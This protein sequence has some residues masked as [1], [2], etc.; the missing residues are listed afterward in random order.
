MDFL[1]VKTFALSLLISLIIFFTTLFYSLENSEKLNET[2]RLVNQTHEVIHKCKSL[3]FKLFNLE[4]NVRTYYVTGQERFIENFPEKIQ[5]LENLAKEL[6]NSI[7]ENPSQVKNLIKLKELISK[8]KGVFLAGIKTYKNRNGNSDSTFFKVPLKGAMVSDLIIQEF[9]KIEKI[10]RQLLA[11][12][13]QMINT[14]QK[15][16][17]IFN[18][19]GGLCAL[20]MAAI[21]IGKLFHHLKEL[22]MAQT[23]LQ[24]QEEKLRIIYNSTSDALL[25]LDC[26]NFY[27]L[28]CNHTTLELFEEERKE[29]FLGTDFFEMGNVLSRNEGKDSIYAFIK[30]SKTWSKEVVFKTKTDTVFWGEVSFSKTVIDKNERIIARITD[31]TK[32]KNAEKEVHETSKIL[33]GILNNLPVIVYKLDSIGTITLSKGKGLRTVGLLEEQMIGENVYKHFPHIE[34][35]MTNGY[36]WNSYVFTTNQQANGKDFFM[37]HYLFKDPDNEGGLIGFAVD[38]TANKEAE[39]AL[40]DEKQKAEMAAKARQ[41]FLST[42]SHEIRTPL[43][44]IIGMTHLLLQ[45]KLTE[46]QQQRLNI[47]KFSGENLL[48]TLND[49]LDFSKIESGGVE[50]SQSDF[51]LTDIIRNTKDSFQSLADKK[52]IKLKLV[53]EDNLPLYLKGDSHRLQQVLNNLLNNA[54]KFT[55]KGSVTIQVN[56]EDQSDEK[57][58]LFISVADTGIG[59]PA[60]KLETIFE[61]FKQA[62]AETSRK[63]GGTGLGLAII[64]NIVEMQGGRIELES[65]ENEGSVFK[66]YISYQKSLIQEKDEV[67]EEELVS[68][69]GARVLYVEDVAVNQLLLEGFCEL[70]NVELDV[71]SSGKEAIAQVQ[72][73]KYDLI[74]MDIQMPEMDGYETT[75]R[76]RT[77]QGDY[78]NRVPIIALSAEVSEDVKTKIYKAGMNGFLSKPIVPSELHSSIKK[79]LPEAKI[80]GLGNLNFP[81]L[82]LDTNHDAVSFEI[83]DKLFIKQEKEYVMFLDN[84]LSDFAKNLKE[85]K[86]SIKEKD[87]EVFSDVRH[88]LLSI[89]KIMQTQQ[90][91]DILDSIKKEFNSGIFSEREKAIDELNFAFD[92]INEKIN[93]KIE[94]L[95]S[96]PR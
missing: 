40:I 49:I 82:S 48:N 79:H 28:D 44:A 56:L 78:Y 32:R 33:E 74:L 6:E 55:E 38:I 83:L 91:L 22:R 25:V 1:K 42:M 51:H 23:E 34:S 86:N 43:N 8:R 68:L 11:K 45:D 61:P 84:L 64:K 14:S 95:K 4:S 92:Q 24:Q 36:H 37:E 77:I 90:V 47:L 7:S 9:N 13:S 30:E 18:F 52:G 21:S 72:K 66:V 58:Q 27:I 3:E 94:S 63:F 20:F 96:I 35:D 67:F 69:R 2:T 59:I 81:D 53:L 60:N 17:F 39:K 80:K 46:Q 65:K 12:R 15:E 62:E 19:I 5:E 85:M 93:G 70:W 57:S 75:R 87:G 50:F 76:I 71:A 10:E 29:D 88:K 73:R 54:I 31:V 89:L 26:E 16:A 41:K